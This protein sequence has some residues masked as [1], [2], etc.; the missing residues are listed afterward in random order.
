MRRKDYILLAESLHRTMPVKGCHSGRSMFHS[1]ACFQNCYDSWNRVA[2][3]I[4]NG[5]ASDNPRF[6]REH[7]LAVVR[8]EKDL[9]SRPARK[10]TQTEEPY[11]YSKIRTSGLSL[12]APQRKQKPWPCCQGLGQHD[13]TCVRYG[14]PK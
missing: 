10:F 3:D 1:E 4:S 13:I 7:F 8:G 14:Q 9:N 5:L 12:D 6:D 2:Q 11:Q